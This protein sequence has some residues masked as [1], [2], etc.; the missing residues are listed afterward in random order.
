MNP[1]LRKE[2]QGLI[3]PLDPLYTVQQSMNAILGEQHMIC[4]PRLMYLPFV[5][6]A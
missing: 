6:R 1:T 4:I 3:P 2:L 5:S